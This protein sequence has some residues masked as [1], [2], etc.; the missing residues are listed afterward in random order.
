MAVLCDFR[1]GPGAH[2]ISFMR[3][4]SIHRGCELVLPQATAGDG[5]S[6]HVGTARGGRSVAY[7]PAL[8]SPLWVAKRFF[9][10]RSFAF[11]FGGVARCNFS[12]AATGRFGLG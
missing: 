4:R 11:G 6:R 1:S 10:A 8:S 2:G 7:I 9:S 3:H 12:A 5:F